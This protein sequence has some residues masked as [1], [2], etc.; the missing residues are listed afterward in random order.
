MRFVLR[1][2]VLGACAI[3]TVAAAT[4]AIADPADLG[5]RRLALGTGEVEPLFRVGLDSAHR[6]LISS[7][8]TYKII[9]PATG[10]TIWKPKHRGEIAVVAEGGPTEGVSSVFR[11]QVGAFGNLEAA[12]IERKRM[13]ERFGQPAVVRH[14]P[15]RGSWRVR[16]GQASN[17]DALG[18]L[19]ERLRAEGVDGP[20]IVEEAA[21]AT[22]DVSLRV[23]NESFESFPTGLRR[24]VVVPTG[25]NRIA[26]EG[27]SY[28]GVIELRVSAFGTVRAVNWVG[29]EVYLLGV[30]PAELGPA[31]WP[32]LEALKAQAVAARTYAWRNRGQFEDEGFD[33]CHTPRC[34]VYA[35]ASAEHPLSDRAVAETRGQILTWEG[36]PIS[37]LYT[38]TCGGHTEDGGE[39]FP[40]EKAPYLH[41]VPCRAESEALNVLMLELE[42]AAVTPVIAEDGRDVTRDGALLSAAGVLGPGWGEAASRRPTPEGL[43]AWTTAVARLSGRPEPSG[44]PGPVGDL[45]QAASSLVADL[46][47][48][49]RADLLVAEG[50]LPAVLRDPEAAALPPEQSRAL[51]YLALAEAIVPFADGSFHVGEPPSAARLL[52]ALARIGEGYRAFGL[53]EA[54]VS[55]RAGRSIR[56]YRGTSE[57]TL[58]VRES[59]L[60]FS[61]TG[62]KSVP[63]ERLELWPGDRVRYRTDNEGGVD[64]LEVMPPVKGTS[65]DRSSSVYSWEVRQSRRKLESAVNR[66]V[67]VGRLED[68]RV[69]RRGRSGRAVELEVV[70]SAGKTVVRGFDIRRLLGLRETLTVIEV[71]RDPAGRLEAVVFAGKGWGHGV[72]L[73]QVGAYGMALRGSKY[74]EILGHYYR[75][76]RLQDLSGT[77]S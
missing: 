16:V 59:P 5:L 68:L 76:A 1:A 14:V 28:R 57:V 44:D 18:E 54:T 64:F 39:I 56:F 15:D 26:V 61:R 66:R 25:R 38:A 72:G 7:S 19:M 58:P 52:P 13:Q 22:G 11:I 3:A 10:K 27:K 17:R 40:E 63:V 12:E 41:G 67:S 55:G 43:R 42:G 23:V 51:A 33:L 21:E 45:G 70:G 2:V 62:G 77:G 69:L 20:W 47:W 73:C 71:Q 74:Q 32:Q 24:I 36:K 60:L 65:D 4:P 46:S 29:L 50:D 49:E 9:D 34:Q 35:G 53:K 48:S 6:L 37:A 8:A 75:G 31:Q 30:V